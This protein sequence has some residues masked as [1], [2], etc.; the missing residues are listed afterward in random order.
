[1]FHLCHLG[2]ERPKYN[3]YI[4]GYYPNIVSSK[5]DHCKTE[6]TEWMN[7]LLA[8][9]VKRLTVFV[10]NNYFRI[11]NDQGFDVEECHRCGFALNGQDPDDRYNTLYMAFNDDIQGKHSNAYGVCHVKIHWVCPDC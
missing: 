9:D 2:T 8:P 1:M 3:A 4:L 5:S 6:T 11:Q 7:T 10:A